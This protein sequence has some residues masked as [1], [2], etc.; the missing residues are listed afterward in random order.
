MTEAASRV[1]ARIG[2][3]DVDIQRLGMAAMRFI[4]AIE[5]GEHEILWSAASSTMRNAMLKE[6]AESHNRWQCYLQAKE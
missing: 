5:Q 2:L 6:V 4:S 1:A 3:E